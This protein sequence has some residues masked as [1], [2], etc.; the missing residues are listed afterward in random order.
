MSENEYE[1]IADRVISEF[2]QSPPDWSK[3]SLDEIQRAYGGLIGWRK[4]QRT[5]KKKNQEEWTRNGENIRTIQTVLA[6]KW[7]ER[8][9][10]A[11]LQKIVTM[12]ANCSDPD[13][14]N[15]YDDLLLA[16]LKTAYTKL[17][18]SDEGI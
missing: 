18:E 6:G 15:N 8:G 14:I 11:L 7:A 13:R 10:A 9:K 2:R 4:K 12:E 1:T 3:Y 17:R 16:E 5:R